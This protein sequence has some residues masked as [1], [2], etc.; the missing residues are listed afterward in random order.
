LAGALERIGAGHVEV[1]KDHVAQ[2]VRGAGIAQ[3]DFGHQL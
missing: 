2:S 3:H 1:A